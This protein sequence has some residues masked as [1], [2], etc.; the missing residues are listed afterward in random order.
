MIV[1]PTVTLECLLQILP[2]FV[3][4]SRQHIAD[5]AIEALDHPV[6]LGV[7]RTDEQVF[8]MMLCTGLVEK[9]ASCRLT[10]TAR[11]ETI[12]EALSIVCQHL[13]NL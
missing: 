12:G 1:E 13:L 4:S 8:D 10:F 7:T 5:T 11:R 3:A 2:R 6:G 9:M